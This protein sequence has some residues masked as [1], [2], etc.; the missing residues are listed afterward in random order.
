[1]AR[2]LRAVLE[3]RLRG[4]GPFSRT[5]VLPGLKQRAEFVEN[6][7]LSRCITLCKPPS[8]AFSSA[9]RSSTRQILQEKQERPQRR[10]DETHALRC[11]TERRS[12]VGAYLH[13][14]G[15]GSI[16]NA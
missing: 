14:A 13:N 7:P 5:S 8:W 4:S 1:M 2:S 3:R 16:S 9:F 12:R 15:L 10:K 11:G 6:A